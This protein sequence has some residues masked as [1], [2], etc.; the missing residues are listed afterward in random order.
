[1]PIKQTNTDEDEHSDCRKKSRSTE[2]IDVIRVIY[3]LRIIVS[4][5]CLYT[6]VCAWPAREPSASLH[7]LPKSTIGTTAC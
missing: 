4:S 2:L 6:L 7:V 1:M 5:A 3:S